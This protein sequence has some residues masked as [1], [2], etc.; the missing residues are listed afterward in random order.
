MN[1]D[2]GRSES[3]PVPGEPGG[4][5]RVD[6]ASGPR[7]MEIQRT[8]GEPL[9]RIRPSVLGRFMLLLLIAA[10]FNPAPVAAVPD[11]P[12]F[13]DQYLPRTS[14]LPEGFLL[15]EVGSRT[16]PEIFG[17]FPDPTDAA[18]RFSQAD[19]RQNAYRVFA[20][21]DG[22]IVLDTSA[23]LFSSDA[24][25]R[26]MAPYFAVARASSPGLTML[27]A[28]RPESCTTSIAGMP[29]PGFSEH[30]IILCVGRIVVRIS[31]VS[32]TTSPEPPAWA[33]AL[34]VLDRPPNR[35]PFRPETVPAPPDSPSFRT[36]ARISSP[37][38]IETALST[39]TRHAGTP[40]DPVPIREYLTIDDWQVSVLGVMMNANMAMWAFDRSSSRLPTGFRYLLVEVGMENRRAEDRDPRSLVF[41]AGTTAQAPECGVAP[42][43]PIIRA[44]A[45]TLVGLGGYASGYL[46]LLVPEAE[47]DDLLL[48]IRSRLNSDPGHA[49]Y[50]RLR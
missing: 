32:T 20:T 33:A 14:E 34:A 45:A 29:R 41:S 30:T 15:L 36:E 25:A 24:A 43:F 28:S 17:A 18:R 12:F 8:P 1:R 31:S 3:R 48:V 44:D 4:D 9:L 21:A 35:T 5:G 27:P 2:R 19:W 38:E 42:P 16:A 10:S 11:F 50:F 6:R 37:A 7:R 26:E 13:L 39:P 23:H 40:G 22:A 46:C 47:H 49:T